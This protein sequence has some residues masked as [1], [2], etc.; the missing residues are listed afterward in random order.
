MGSFAVVTDNSKQKAFEE[1]LRIYGGQFRSFSSRLLKIQAR[2]R[3]RISK[4][5]HYNLG[6]AVLAVKLT[7]KSTRMRLAPD[8]ANE[9]C[10]ECAWLVRLADEIVQRFRELCGDMGPLIIEELGPTAA[11]RM[12]VEDF[13]SSHATVYEVDVDDLDDPLDPEAQLLFHRVLQECLDNVARH[14]AAPRVAFAFKRENGLVSFRI[15]DN[16]ISF[17]DDHHQSGSLPASNLELITIAER[18]WL[19]GGSLDI[20]RAE[21]NTSI[22]F[23]IPLKA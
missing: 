10:G 11:M 6:Q 14:A 8:E 15:A 21:G 1:R 20:G 19:L 4:E 23:S 18:V 5:V 13:A 12:L 16:G 7:T 2:E 22:R 17:V 3:K 9:P